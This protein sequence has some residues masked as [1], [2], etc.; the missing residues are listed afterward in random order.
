MLCGR[1]LGIDRAKSSQGRRVRAPMENGTS[2]WEDV[3][4]LHL[5]S[6]AVLS[7]PV[8]CLTAHR[9]G[10][11][12]DSPQLLRKWI[13]FAEFQERSRIVHDQLQYARGES[14]LKIAWIPNFL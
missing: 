7:C 4:V 3:R 11:L 10:F 9:L 6:A 13:P 2:S 5:S 14:L 1:F 12:Y 8:H